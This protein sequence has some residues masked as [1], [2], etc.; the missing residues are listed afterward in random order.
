MKKR[1]LCGKIVSLV[2]AGAMT[3]GSI[4]PVWA[5]ERTAKSASQ[6]TLSEAKEL[7]LKF[8]GSLEDSSKNKIAVTPN[9]DVSY[10]EDGISDKALSLD[11]ATYLDLGTSASLQPEEMTVSFWLRATKTLSNEHI[12]MWNKNQW[13]EAGWYL[14][15]LNDSKPLVL[16]VGASNQRLKEF[17][18]LANRSDFFPIGEWVHIAVTYS[19]ATE[20]A[21]F[22]RNGEK[23]TA[24]STGKDEGSG[25]LTPVGNDTEH[26][27]LGFNGP[28]YG[29]GYADLDLDEYVIYSSVATADEV[30]EVYEENMIQLTD[31]E[32]VDADVAALDPFAG[33]DKSAIRTS[34]SL[35][36]KG[37]KGS[38]ISWES[39]NPEVMSTSGKLTRPVDSDVAVT[40]TATISYGDV[41]ETKKFE[42]TVLKRGPESDIV[43]PEN[44]YT[45]YKENQFALDDVIVTDDYYKGAQDLDIDFL[46]AFDNDRLLVG[47]R[48]NAGI[49]TSAARYNG[50]ENSLIAGHDVGHYLSA[51]A[52]GVM[53]TGDEELASKLEDLIAGLHD[54]QDAAGYG[55]SKEGFLFGG[56]VRDKN[57]VELQFD[58]VQGEAT[59]NTWVPWYNMH[60]VIQ[61]LVDT[62]KYTGNKEALVVASN[63]GD[64]VYNRVSQW[65]DSKRR[66]V[67]GIE[68]GGMN[69]CMYELYKF[70]HKEEHKEAAHKFDETELYS[71]VFSG[72]DKLKGRHANTTIP[73]FLGALNRYVALKEVDNI[74][75]DSYLK[76]A[77]DF[78]ELVTDK[79]TY[80]TGG[81]SDMEHFRGDNE[82]DETRTQ[83]NCE[84]C[85]A[86]NMLKLSKE[87]F[88]ITG[89]K[90]YADYYEN[91]L[92]N[93]I[94][95]AINE[96]GGFSYF[97]PMATGYYK[98]FGTSDPATNM[99]WCC[100]GTGM[101]NYTKLGDSIYFKTDDSIIVNQYVSS[102]VL[103]AEKNIKLT[104]EADV[105]NSEE[106]RFTISLLSGAQ[107]EAAVKL[108]V[109]DWTTG[110]VTVKVNDETISDPTEENDYIVLNRAWKDGDT[111]TMTYPM[112]VVAYGL[113]DNAYV[114]AFKYGPTV[115]AAKLGREEWGK[116]VGAGV[117][118]T[119]PAFKVVGDE[120]VRL[121]IPYGKT[122]K[123]VLGTETLAI[124]G[125]GTT[126]EFMNN[127]SSHLE[128]TEGKP[129]FRIRGTDA[130]D[131]FGGEGLTF[132]PFN[133]L[134]DERYG[135]YWY[136]ESVEDSSPENIMKKKEEGRF[137]EAVVDSIQ[138]GYGQYESDSIH[139]LQ[140]K[141]SAFETGVAGF[142]SSR[143]AGVN[144]YF[145]YN[146][147]VDKNATN[148]L[149]CQFAKA[150]AGKTI[151]ITIGGTTFDYT[152]ENIAGD[153]VT[154]QKYFEIPAEE[155]KK[156]ETLTVESDTYDIVKVK[157]ESGKASEES[158]RIVNG[159]FMMR[160][161]SNKAALTS[162]TASVAGMKSSNG[163]YTLKV[164]LG[165]KQVAITFKLA[166][167][168]GLLYIDDKLVNDAKPQKFA[169]EGEETKEFSLRVYA[170]D[171]VT[172]KDY[173]LKLIHEDGLAPGEEIVVNGDINGQAD[174]NPYGD[175]TISLGYATNH[176]APNS[177]KINRTGKEAG[178]YQDIS[179]KVKAGATY[180]VDSYFIFKEG[181]EHNANPAPNADFNVSILYGEGE[182]QKKDVMVTKNVEVVDGG[183]NEW[184]NLSGEYTVPKDADTSK[185]VILL[186]I[187]TGKEP[188]EDGIYAFFIDDISMKMQGSPE[189]EEPTATPTMTPTPAPTATPTM[190]PTATP[191]TAPSATPANT[192]GPAGIEQNSVHKVGNYKYKIT[193]NLTNGKG[194]VML[195]GLKS[196][197]LKKK[198]KKITVPKTVNISGVNFKVTAIGAKAFSNCTK[199]KQAVVGSNVTKIGA[200]AF[201]KCK[202]LKKIT[203]KGKKLKSVG[204]N[205]FKKIHA[206]AVIKVPKSKLKGYK[207]LLKKKGQGKSVKIKK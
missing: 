4:N 113:P 196:N 197:S 148:S 52:Q 163:N 46:K 6:T 161:Y 22:Y 138:P 198:L 41:T 124:Q 29:G 154:Y 44:Q 79:H 110:S 139:Q 101:E 151:K 106:A 184:A 23:V 204:K 182:A 98:V 130:E 33:K 179:G 89:K 9:K 104:Q 105:T 116:E 83:T 87:L 135:I 48:E 49:K 95:C 16:S 91:T 20:T 162:V 195:S 102:E 26:R 93:A 194:T 140:E 146:M 58:V 59:G 131:V 164:P 207:K 77:E 19:T 25:K 165:V 51:A 185:V 181:A 18:V 74:S 27:Y 205:A 153:D 133:T 34:V 169:L 99:F 159:L 136:Y 88:K 156:A 63:L 172:Y 70:T 177:L 188:G 2:L 78:W 57:N 42:I 73:K 15:S 123:Q 178:A 94:M 149:L 14:S 43:V 66:T 167:R 24:T 125:T 190:T 3:I 8:D 50:W 121:E 45:A 120:K 60:K 137:A 39:S 111:I 112:D 5:Q 126:D 76:Y 180:D 92:R 129:E 141:N 122:I 69:D 134:N 202:K 11:G 65:S 7:E 175:A 86:H 193:S 61:G 54:C 176:S 158:A 173:T 152:V 203:I 145:T 168:T 62:Y 127:I 144:G 103:W 82:L 32:I 38:T 17:E 100:T 118:L 96:E 114:Y 90:K 37:R 201:Y 206:K 47:F 13:D 108:R 84:S 80:I 132:V 21:V 143:K 199:V 155:V 192:P 35:P 147:L 160:A 30:R 28:A 128:K 200:K 142:G 31:R 1:L 67:L 40:L 36:T 170:Q 187:A 71:T 64:W 119:A 115:L 72:K 171:H 107:S 53:T 68:Y 81:T 97:T 85:C 12:I 109:P 191:P 166:D 186:E 183:S 10:A 117:N 56:E 189:D 150:D 174:W 55:G 157:F 75:E